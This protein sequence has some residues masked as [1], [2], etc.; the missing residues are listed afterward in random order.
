MKATFENHKTLQSII[1]NLQAQIDT[2]YLKD[3][4]EEKS[5]KEEE[6]QNMIVL[7]AQERNDIEYELRKD[8]DYS[9]T[10]INSQN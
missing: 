8:E 4:N 2:L 7:I 10:Y 9:N 3:W 1:D 6:L 5:I